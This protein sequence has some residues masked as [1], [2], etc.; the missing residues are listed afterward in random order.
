MYILYNSKHITSSRLPLSSRMALSRPSAKSL[1]LR[2]CVLKTGN[3]VIA[4]PVLSLEITGRGFA[5]N[6]SLR[7][8]PDAP[9][10]TCRLNMLAVPQYTIHTAQRKRRLHL[11]KAGG[12]QDGARETSG[13]L[14]WRTDC[15]LSLVNTTGLL[16]YVSCGFSTVWFLSTRTNER[17]SALQAAW[18]FVAAMKAAV[19]TR[20]HGVVCNR[21]WW[22]VPSVSTQ[23]LTQHRRTGRAE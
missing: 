23:K 9:R 18:A 13:A 16:P 1:F 21:T 12:A 2:R 14:C 5:F 10:V 11:R 6:E 3:L 8:R 15:R 22:R 19:V 20:L 4:S 17:C 7:R